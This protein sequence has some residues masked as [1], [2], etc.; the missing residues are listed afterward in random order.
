VLSRNTGKTQVKLE[1][2][3][4]HWDPGLRTCRLGRQAAS[5]GTP[6][7]SSGQGNPYS[8]KD[9]ARLECDGNVKTLPL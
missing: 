7:A 2:G 8:G 6:S 5:L 1:G 9:I 4:L 3:G